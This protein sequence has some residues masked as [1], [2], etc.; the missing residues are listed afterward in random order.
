MI[1]RGVGRGCLSA[2]GGRLPDAHDLEL[3]D[4]LQVV[5]RHAV[6]PVEL[7]HDDE[8]NVGDEE[9]RQQLKWREMLRQ[10]GCKIGRG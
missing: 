9:Q 8:D 5:Q 10:S 7:Q 1:A 3:R 4:L 2:Q 6:H